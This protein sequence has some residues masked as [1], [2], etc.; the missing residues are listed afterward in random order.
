MNK[1]GNNASAINNS[2]MEIGK[3]SV[4]ASVKNKATGKWSSYK[5]LGL[6]TAMSIAFDKTRT[7]INQSNFEKNYIFKSIVTEQTVTLTIDFREFKV[8]NLKLMLNSKSKK[9]ASAT[10]TLEVTLEK[11]SITKNE[12][13]FI[14]LKG[15]V[16][17]I[18]SVT[19]A[20]SNVLVLNKN[21]KIQNGSLYIM[22]TDEQTAASASSVVTTADEV[23][24]EIIFKTR[25]HEVLEF[26]TEEESE[27]RLYIEMYNTLDPGKLKQYYIHRTKFS[28]DSLPIKADNDD[29]LSY[30]ATCVLLPSEEISDPAESVYYKL[31]VID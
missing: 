3:G 21:Y 30:T 8:D 11:D 26:D 4:Y 15:G 24:L 17:E 25:A 19:V 28:A 10:D 31:V 2:V 1:F 12:G 16:D 7:D 23:E 22:S 27:I 20:S 9:V 29:A 14:P 5:S 18:T 13:L 6:Q